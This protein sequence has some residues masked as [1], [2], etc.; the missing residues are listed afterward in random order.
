MLSAL[1]EIIDFI[2]DA[3]KAAWRQLIVIILLAAF[4][5]WGLP[6]LWKLLLLLPGPWPWVV[7]AVVVILVLIALWRDGGT[8]TVS[9]PCSLL[10]Y[11]Y[12]PDKCLPTG[13]LGPC[14]EKTGPYPKW[15]GGFALGT[16]AVACTCS[17]ASSTVL[18]GIFATYAKAKGQLSEIQLKELIRAKIVE[19]TG[20]DLSPG[21]QDV[22][23][24]IMEKIQQGA[25]LTPDDLDKLN[26][27]QQP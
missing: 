3:L 6:F 7:V 15:M 27:L 8:I 18:T 17:G 24:K 10:S 19:L 22:I 23:Q 9:G 12:W 1:G 16:Q 20:K 25:Q 2:V 11:R 5:L 13:C 14:T 4:A 26:K 21:D